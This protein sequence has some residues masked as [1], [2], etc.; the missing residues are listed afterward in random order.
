MTEA[1]P[2]AKRQLKRF[3]TLLQCHDFQVQASFGTLVIGRFVGRFSLPPVVR[4]TIPKERRLQRAR[5]S[6]NGLKS[7]DRNRCEKQKQKMWDGN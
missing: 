7:K 1:S 6:K 5:G 3:H 4:D 2:V